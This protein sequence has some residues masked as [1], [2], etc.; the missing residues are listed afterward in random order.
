[1]TNTEKIDR[2]RQ[3]LTEISWLQKKINGLENDGT[4]RTHTKEI[5][6]LTRQINDCKMKLGV[7]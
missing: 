2:E 7:K 3:L 5:A 6:D 1:M 4:R